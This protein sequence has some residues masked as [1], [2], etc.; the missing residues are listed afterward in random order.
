[1]EKQQNSTM[2]SKRRIVLLDELRGLSVLFMVFFHGVYDIV[3]VFGKDLPWFRGFVMQQILQPI[4]AGMFIFLA[5][6]STRYTRS[7]LKRGLITFGLGMVITLST[8]V[9]MPSQ[10][11]V[12]GILHGLGSYMLLFAAFEAV[13]KRL[14]TQYRRR[15]KIPP[16]AG[17]AL[18]FLLFG[19]FYN[20]NYGTIGFFRIPLLEMPQALYQSKI[21][22]LF[23]FPAASFSS[24][25]YFPLLPWFLLFMAGSY[26]GRWTKEGNVPEFFYRSRSTWI[27]WLG[28][29]SLV[30]Y[31]LHQPIIYGLLWVLFAVFP[32]LLR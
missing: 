19:I 4:D 20:V 26:F 28:Q 15:K 8:L 32:G 21:S 5:G 30:I 17:F 18:F 14:P 16:L 10:L 22:F 1:M 23:G 27:G 24:A 25:D 7:N 29:H 6:F 12:F 9:A 3:Y 2:Q 11:I 31:M 13:Q